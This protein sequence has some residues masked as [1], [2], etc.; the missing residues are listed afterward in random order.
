MSNCKCCGEK[1][2]CTCGRLLKTVDIELFGNKITLQVNKT[3]SSMGCYEYFYIGDG[4][5]YYTYNQIDSSGQVPPVP[6][7]TPYKNKKIRIRFHPASVVFDFSI[8]K[9]DNPAFYQPM[10]A[11]YG[12]I[13][14]ENNIFTIE[15]PDARLDPGIVFLNYK[16]E[17]I[18][19]STNEFIAPS[20]FNNTK[21]TELHN[22]TATDVSE[23]LDRYAQD[24]DWKKDIILC[25]TLD[26]E[27]GV[28]ASESQ[29]NFPQLDQCDDW[30]ARIYSY[31][32]DCTTLEGFE[33]DACCKVTTKYTGF[34]IEYNAG[35]EPNGLRVWPTYYTEMT[36]N[37]YPDKILYKYKNKKYRSYCGNSRNNIQDP[38]PEG[39]SHESNTYGC[40]ATI[41]SF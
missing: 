22:A 34:L 14:Q 29:Q 23:N 8:Y 40:P 31:S 19:I 25:S 30:P 12:K 27:G 20:S 39:T 13:S 10:F 4:T 2:I 17:Q 7:R 21:F 24:L 3:I 28:A 15:V 36:E 11:K 26:V 9:G 32:S 33:V 41:E 5:A 16:D 37:T 35:I 1:N 18:A 6:V 38:M